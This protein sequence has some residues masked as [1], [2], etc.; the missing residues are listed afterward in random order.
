M[1]D[2]VVY[3]VMKVLNSRGKSV[4]GSKI[5]VLGL[6]YK[7]NVDDYRESPSF[8]LIEKLEQMGAEVCFNDPYIPEIEMT[9]EYAKYSGRKSTEISVDFDLFLIATAHD[10]YK[11]INFRTL[12]VP[13]VDTRNIINEKDDK[14]FFKA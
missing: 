2:Y 10:E 14:V 12:G 4:K 3:Q 8:H 1:P 11:S 6:A 5:L 13:V 9:R 7:A